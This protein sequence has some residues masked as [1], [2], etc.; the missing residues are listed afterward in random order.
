M[1]IPCRG[2]LQ[3]STTVR[4]IHFMSKGEQTRERI[5][6][7]AMALASRDGLEGLT[8]GNLAEHLGLSKSGLF[9]HFGSK[10]DLQ[11]QVLAHA[12]ERFTE[13][14]L[15]PALAFPRGEARLRMLFTRWIDWGRDAHLPG[16]CIFQAAAAEL[17]DK[18]GKARDMLVD[19]QKSLLDSIERMAR[20]AMEAREFRSD[21]DPRQ[22]AHDMY[23]LVV[24]YHQ[25]HRLL[26][27][28]RETAR[29]N[30]A[31]ERL[32]DAARRP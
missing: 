23:A 17:D 15:K 24:G 11:I 26:R 5:V 31:F 2:G 13:R 16:G 4:I 27:D 32:L 6:E 8:I 20:T 3:K 7:R 19:Q 29:E 1:T 28:R 9:G 25:L 21:L 30:A 22:F 18:P 10:E 12:A 14:V